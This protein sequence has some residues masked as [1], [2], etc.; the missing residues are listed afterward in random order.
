MEDADDGIVLTERERKVLAGLAESI[1]DPWLAGQLAGRDRVALPPR[2]V[3]RPRLD[4]ARLL[5]AVAATGWAA[6][7]LVVAGAALAVMTFTH[8]TVVASLGLLVMGFGLWRLVSDRGDAAVRRW[9][10]RRAEP[11]AAR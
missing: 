9:Q 10:A 7:L 3:N 2:P 8:S 5:A 4:P 6:F 11:P 1:G